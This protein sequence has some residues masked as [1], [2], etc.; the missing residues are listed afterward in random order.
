L[1]FVT[2]LNAWE[3]PFTYQEKDSLIENEH[4]VIFRDSVHENTRVEHMKFL[5]Y[6]SSQ[7]DLTVLHEWTID[8]FAGYS[9]R[10]PQGFDMSVISNRTE[11]KYTE[12]NQKMF[13]SDY[14]L[15]QSN[16]HLEALSVSAA[17]CLNQQDVPSWGLTRTQERINTLNGMYHHPDNSGA[18]VNAYIVDTGIF[19]EHPKFQGR[20]VWGTDTADK[21]PIK[22]DGNGHGTHVAGTVIADTYGLARSGTAIAVKVLGADGSGSNDGV[23]AGV[24][25]AVQ[26]HKTRGVGRSVANMSLGGGFSQALNNAVANAVKAGIIFVVA[27]GNDGRGI[28]PSPDACKH[29]PASEPLALTVGASDSTDYRADY[30]NYGTCVK[31]FAP[32]SAITSLWKETPGVKE[33][34]NTISGTS[35]ASPHVAGVAVKLWSLNPTAKSTQISELL[36]D[37]TTKG[38]L[39]DVKEKKSPDKLVFQDCGAI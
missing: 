17:A 14:N 34:I 18:G 37:M 35:M 38:V 27:A 8:S 32:G 12:A 13:I 6:L 28:I 23:I 3:S 20:A 21:P 5:S 24:A 33:P 11:V 15:V 19:I 10:V 22:K 1:L 2:G 30:S 16:N 26:D 39:K 25:W 7:M 36:L 9:I 29:S 31:L 4:I